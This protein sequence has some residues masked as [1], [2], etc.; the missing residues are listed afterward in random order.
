MNKIVISLVSIMVFIS[1][2]NTK[3]LRSLENNPIS[4]DLSTSQI[5]KVILKSG[6]SHGWTVAKSKTEPHSYL[7]KLFVRSHYLEVLITVEKNSYSVT[8]NDSKELKYNSIQ[9]TI[10]R[11]Y[12]RWVTIFIN[13]INKNLSIAESLAK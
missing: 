4:P 2:A 11:N 9:N 1:C 8:Y 12:Y 3:T 13:D 7:A 6:A 5:E 10:H